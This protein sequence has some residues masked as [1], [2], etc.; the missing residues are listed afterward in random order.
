MVGNDTDEV[1]TPDAPVNVRIRWSTGEVAAVECVY[2]GWKAVDP[3]EPETHVWRM[4]HFERPSP[5]SMPVS[6]LAEKMP[7]Q[8]SIVGFLD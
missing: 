8:T 4:I 7:A 2:E 1:S 5:D 3:G 6:V